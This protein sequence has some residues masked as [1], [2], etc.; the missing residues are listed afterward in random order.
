MQIPAELLAFVREHEATPTLTAYVES[1]PADPA[2]RRRWRV[3]L[4]QGLQAVRDSL[5]QDELETFTQCEADLL[6]RLPSSDDLPMPGGA[7]YFCAA[8]GAALALPLSDIANETEV[9]WGVG[10]RLV[11]FLRTAIST[12]CLVVRLDLE[13]VQFERWRED[14]LTT[15][16][17]LEAERAH[18]IG[19]RMGDAPRQ[20]FHSGT[21][22]FTRADEEQRQREDGHERLRAR[23]LEL[24]GTFAGS[25][26]PI[27]L[28]GPPEASSRFL[29]SLGPEL[30]ER[31]IVA[32]SL[33][34]RTSRSAMDGVVRSALARQGSMERQRRVRSL[35]EQVHTGGRA[36]RGFEEALAAADAGAIAELIFTERAW[37]QDS[38]TIEVLIRRTLLARGEVSWAAPGGT[39]V[40]DGEADGI[41]VALRFPLTTAN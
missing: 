19:P 31:T 18:E 22:G 12:E 15:L 40:L 26:L 21:R 38:Q 1:T 35:L 39:A 14:S 37:R 32:P 3:L 29:A 8:G 36:A 16:A 27:V 17:T 23:A 5:P 10:P 20:G 7:V 2:A 11:P 4:R 41:L 25:Q 6:V 24:L 33:T 9:T 30:A 34:I 28:G 13:H